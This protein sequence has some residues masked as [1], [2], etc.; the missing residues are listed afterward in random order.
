[1]STEIE[2]GDIEIKPFRNGDEVTVQRI[3]DSMSLESRYHRFIQAT[4]RLTAGMRRMLADVDGHKH[5]AWVAW[6]ADRPVGLSRIVVDQFGDFELSVSVVDGMQ[7]RGL[8]RELVSTALASAADA[9]RD[10][11]MIL[12]HPE[13][14][15]SVALFRRMGATFE[16]EFGLL[17][18]RVPTDVMATAA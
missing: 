12:V 7:R 5:R 6:D 13:N 14:H 11:V 1:M 15:A 16:Y 17:N 18:G 2:S 8:G 10:S 3:F 9:G 4:P